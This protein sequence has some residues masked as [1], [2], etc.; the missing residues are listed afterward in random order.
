MC[1]WV[2]FR[3]TDL[4]HALTYLKTMFS[5]TAANREFAA[6]AYVDSGV[7]TVLVA[8]ILGSL[9]LVPVVMH[10]QEQIR[11]RERAAVW[12]VGCDFIRV[13]GVA[14]VLVASAALMT[15]ATHN[16]FIYFRF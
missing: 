14:V 4:P 5:V 16:P 6:S 7:M 9:P 1:G 2:L 8:G 13:T 3:A 15:G 10:W 11:N 12:N